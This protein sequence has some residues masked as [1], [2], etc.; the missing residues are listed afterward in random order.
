MNETN[1]FKPIYY[2]DESGVAV[3]YPNAESTEKDGFDSNSVTQCCN[4]ILKT[5]KGKVWRYVG[6]CK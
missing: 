6:G 2:I 5:Y 3:V 1:E 4:G